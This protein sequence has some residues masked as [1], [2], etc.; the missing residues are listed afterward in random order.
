MTRVAQP[1]LRTR[2]GESDK[3]SKCGGQEGKGPKKDIR[4]SNIKNT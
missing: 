3:R 1:K 2:N 4:E